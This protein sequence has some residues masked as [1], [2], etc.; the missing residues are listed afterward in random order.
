M[1][2]MDYK[3]PSGFLSRYIMLI[4][5]S[6]MVMVTVNKIVCFLRV[7]LNDTKLQINYLFLVEKLLHFI[8]A[9]NKF[10]I[11]KRNGFY[12]QSQNQFP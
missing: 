7:Y 6:I 3:R 8:G 9:I 5:M 4:I 11:R 2:G 10:E 1:Y 12:L